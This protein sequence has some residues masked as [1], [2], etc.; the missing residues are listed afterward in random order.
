MQRTVTHVS[1]RVLPMCPVHTLSL[2]VGVLPTVD[3]G[4]NSASRQRCL[5]QA[6]LTRSGWLVRVDPAWKTPG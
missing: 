3:N 6:S 1:E 2:A 4:S 5:I